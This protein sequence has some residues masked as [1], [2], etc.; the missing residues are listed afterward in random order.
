MRSQKEYLKLGRF[1]Q[2]RW[3]VPAARAEGV[4]A[5]VLEPALLPICTD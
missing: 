1:W 3:T 5:G 4:T 2:L